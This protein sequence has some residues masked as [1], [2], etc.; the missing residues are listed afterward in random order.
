M[1]LSGLRRRFQAVQNLLG[2]PLGPDA[3][4]LEIRAAVVDAIETRA[5]PI[6]RG[7]RALPCNRIIV[8]VLARTTGDR[9]SLELTFAELDARVRERLQEIRCDPPDPF[10]LSVS[11]LKKAPSD[12][13]DGQLFSVDCQSRA[14]PDP[15]PPSSSVPWVRVSVLKGT[16]T[17]KV[18]TFKE[19]TIL[20][21]RTSEVKESAG[22]GRRNQ[23][24]F[25]DANSSV[26]RAH[27]RLKF[28]PVRRKYQLLDDGS[29]HGTLV[30]RRG[31]TIQVPKRDPRGVLVQSGDEI[32]LGH[33]SV[34]VVI[35]SDTT[36]LTKSS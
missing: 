7:R 22:R 24:A 35:G 12:W 34:R 1:R 9:S 25:E 19:S 13:V 20:M 27:A 32:Q 3:K 30:V 31:E 23:V 5:E 29:V 18:Y 21:G 33:A 36:G 10:D 17:K 6:G 26:S 4:P 2:G 8:R 11:F 16:A 14:K 15:A 28:D